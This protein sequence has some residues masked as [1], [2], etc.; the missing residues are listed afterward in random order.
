MYS[1]Q[2]YT[3]KSVICG[4]LVNL[5]G[6]FDFLLQVKNNRVSDFTHPF[7]GAVVDGGFQPLLFSK[8]VVTVISANIL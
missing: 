2:R 7:R 1:I 6:N 5:A 3:I 4:R 8:I